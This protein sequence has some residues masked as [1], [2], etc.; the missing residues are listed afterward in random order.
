MLR[1][2]CMTSFFQRFQR[3]RGRGWGDR[4]VGALKRSDV[5]SPSS[6]NSESIRSHLFEFFTVLR[7]SAGS[8]HGRQ[9]QLFRHN[10]E[11]KPI[12]QAT[13]NPRAAT[14]LTRDV[15]PRPVVDVGVT[16]RRRRE[17]AACSSRLGRWVVV[18]TSWAFETRRE[19]DLRRSKHQRRMARRSLTRDQREDRQTVWYHVQGDNFRDCLSCLFIISHNRLDVVNNRM[20]LPTYAAYDCSV[21]TEVPSLS[22]V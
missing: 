16:E 19:R 11:R 12:V 1:R 14:E 6:D 3:Y 18:S 13:A 4:D 15:R 2:K 20:A 9:R 5:L 10:M 17:G 8:Q 7:P 21:N 22:R